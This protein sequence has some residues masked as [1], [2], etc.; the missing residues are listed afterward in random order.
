MSST[1]SQIIYA[2]SDKIPQHA[3]SIFLAGSTNTGSQATDAATDWRKT[4]SESLA[5]RPITIY[6]PYRADWD[7]SWRE[8][9]YFTPFREQL[10]WE[11][12]MQEKADLVVVHFEADAEAQLSLLEFG[13]WVRAPGKTVVVCPDGFSKK[14]NVQVVCKRFD[15]EMLDTPEQVKDAVVRKLVLDEPGSP[16]SLGRVRSR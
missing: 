3:K 10:E 8:D 15:V 12:D 1:K 14:G 11:L 6:N 5:D 2:P 7:S 9:I 16:T 13:I 4:V